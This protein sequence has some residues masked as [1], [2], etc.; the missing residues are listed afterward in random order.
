M[1]TTSSWRGR[2]IIPIGDKTELCGVS[3]DTVS[4]TNAPSDTAT[5]EPMTTPPRSAPDGTAFKAS[6]LPCRTA[7]ATSVTCASSSGSMPLREMNASPPRA[8]ATAFPTIAGAAPTTPGTA[9]S[10]AV[11]SSTSANPPPV[12]FQT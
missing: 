2:G 9:V 12:I 11:S 6:R 5:P 7:R 1:P 4:P 3:T 8:V 10:R